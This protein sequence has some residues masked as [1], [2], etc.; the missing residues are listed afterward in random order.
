[1][2]GIGDGFAVIVLPAYLPALSYDPVAIGAI[3]TAALLGTAAL[4]LGVG[5]IASRHD[6]RTLTLLGAALMAATGLAF[7]NEDSFGD[8]IKA[9]WH[10]AGEP[11]TFQSNW[12]IDCVA[13]HLKAVA[14]REIKGPGPL[15]FTLPPRWAS[16]MTSHAAAGQLQQ[17]PTAREGGLF[18]RTWFDN[19]VKYVPDLSRMQLVRAWDRCT[20]ER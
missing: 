8:F 11:Q 1:V 18:K 14:R 2:R 9:A 3:L 19:P 12:H 10:H 6:L 7:A 5:V 15:I 20:W 17:R 4:T 13:D 16:S